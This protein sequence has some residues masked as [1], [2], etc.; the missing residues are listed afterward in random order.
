VEGENANL[1]AEEEC[2]ECSCSCSDN[3]ESSVYAEA[4]FADEVRATLQELGA[5]S[6]GLCWSN[7]DVECGYNPKL[8]I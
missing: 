6:M 3:E 8:H 1:T 7:C 4:D 5:V 2:S